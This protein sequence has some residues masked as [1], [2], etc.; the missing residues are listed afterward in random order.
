MSYSLP[1]SMRRFERFSMPAAEQR[2]SE[3]LGLVW[4]KQMQD[5]DLTNA[6]AELL[7]SLF[8]LLQR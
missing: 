1:A 3:A 7:P 4:D 2:L 5:W 8:S 6:N